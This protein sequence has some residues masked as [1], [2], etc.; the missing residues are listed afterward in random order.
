MKIIATSISRTV[1]NHASVTAQVAAMPDP[2]RMSIEEVI[3]RITNLNDGLRQFWSSAHGWASLETAELLGRSRL[4]WQ[5]SLSRCLTLWVEQ[6]AAEEAGHLILASANL[7][8]LVEGSLKLFLSVWYETYKEDV[9]AIKKNGELQ[10]PDVLQLERIRHFFR[11][12]I[13][14]DS[15]DNFVERVQQRRN[16]IHAFKNRDIGTHDEFLA[17]VRKYLNLLRYINSRL[18]YPDEMYIPQEG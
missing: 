7:G 17:D 12:R 13:W 16:A 8:S 9:E 5:V 11:K 10:E 4:D 3:R 2:D 1:T 14:D 15:Y 18:P 6:P